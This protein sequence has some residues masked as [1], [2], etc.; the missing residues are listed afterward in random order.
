MAWSFAKKGKRETEAGAPAG[1]NAVEPLVIA[2]ETI[3]LGTSRRRYSSVIDFIPCDKNG[4]QLPF[5]VISNTSATNTSGSLSDSIYA[6]HTRNGTYTQLKHLRDCNFAHDK[7]QGTTY[8]D[9]DTNQ[10]VR[11]VD[12]SYIGQYPYYKISTMQKGAEVNATTIGFAVI[13]GIPNENTAR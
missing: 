8:K 12:P 4:K 3:N 5:V 10:R 1:F 2:T 9:L 7:D 11:Y 13:I 6:C